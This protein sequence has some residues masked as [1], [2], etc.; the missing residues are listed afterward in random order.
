MFD[1]HHRM[2]YYA[3]EDIKE[4]GG[5]WN[6]KAKCWVLPTEESWQ[7]AWDLCEF[8]GPNEVEDTESHEENYRGLGNP[9][10]LKGQSADTVKSGQVFA[11]VGN[12]SRQMLEEWIVC[13]QVDHPMA[14]AGDFAC[15][16]LRTGGMRFLSPVKIASYSWR[17]VKLDLAKKAWNR[18]TSE[19]RW[20]AA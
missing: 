4:L 3:K 15:V 19:R 20:E 2:S 10:P 13:C 18:F 5:K 12:D 1:L 11:G 8:H 7:Q 6:P 17:E 16:N 9:I 14:D